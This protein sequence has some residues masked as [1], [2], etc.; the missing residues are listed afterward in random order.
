MLC[1]LLRIAS[2]SVEKTTKLKYQ[3][4]SFNM[5]FFSSFRAEISSLRVAGF[6]FSSFRMALFRLFVF[7][8][9]VFS[10]FRM[11][12]FRHE[13]LKWHKPASISNA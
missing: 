8:H 13:K 10:S 9:G 2:S 12:S 5:A 11:A 3:M 1:V 6:I 7:L 4:A